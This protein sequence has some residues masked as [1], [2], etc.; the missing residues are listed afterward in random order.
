MVINA[1][2]KK[3]IFLIFIVLHSLIIFSQESDNVKRFYFK[4][5]LQKEMTIPFKLISNLVVIPISINGSDTLNFILDTGLRFTILTLL[6]EGDSIKFDYAKQTI[7]SGLGEEEDSKAWITYGNKIE[8]SKITGDFLNVYVLE[9]DRFNLSS[10]MGIEINGLIGYD[11]FNSFIVK[12]DYSKQ[13]IT[14]YD[15]DK[16]KYKKNHHR[17]AKYSIELY[18]LKPYIK[19]PITFENDSVS[20]VKLLIDNGSSDALWLFPN[21]DKNIKYPEKGKEYYL[22]QGLNGNIYGKQ[23]R[24]KSLQIGKH[25]LEDVTTSFPDSTSVRFALLNDVQGRNGSIGSEIFRRFTMIIDYSN[26]QVLFKPNENFSD[27]FNFNLSGIEITTPYIGLPVYQVT[28]VRIDSPA[29][30]AGVKIGDQIVAINNIN[31]VSYTF[32]DIILLFRSKVGRKI[33]LK[34][35]RNGETIIVTFRLEEF[36]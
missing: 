16:F 27:E 32:N 8:I 10:Q 1:R 14:F 7:I 6:P 28:Q 5:S 13:K 36:I 26:N 19:L 29:Y 9:E 11:I 15:S 22:G 3:P 23:N 12:I 21:T 25:F 2:L 18:N 17:W 34:L 4:D 24:I 20:I 30:K 31:S 35:N 33:K